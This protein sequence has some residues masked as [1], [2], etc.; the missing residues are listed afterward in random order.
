MARVRSRWKLVVFGSAAARRLVP[1]AALRSLSFGETTAL[2]N[3][4]GVLVLARRTA[5]AAPVITGALG[6]GALSLVVA[7]TAAAVQLVIATLLGLIVG[8]VCL[9]VLCHH[10]LPKLST[11]YEPFEAAAC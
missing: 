6:I 10:T 3:P 5:Q 1:A 9:F 4:T 11:E 7:S 2:L 8:P